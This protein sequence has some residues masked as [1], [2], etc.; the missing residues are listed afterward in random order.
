MRIQ[1]E[2]QP[3]CFERKNLS[4]P[5]VVDDYDTIYSVIQDIFNGHKV[6]D[7]WIGIFFGD[8]PNREPPTQ[9]LIETLPFSSFQDRR[10]KTEAQ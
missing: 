2:L 4:S 7:M 8:S 1:L 10:K 9:I 6:D 3:T 5:Q